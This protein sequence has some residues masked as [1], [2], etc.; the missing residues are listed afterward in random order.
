MN[1][2]MLQQL[3]ILPTYLQSPF[4]RQQ[5]RSLESLKDKQIFHAVNNGKSIVLLRAVAIHVH[6]PFQ[7]S[8]EGYA[9]WIFDRQPFKLWPSFSIVQSEYNSLAIPLPNSHYPLSNST[10]SSGQCLGQETDKG[11]DWFSCARVKCRPWLAFKGQKLDIDQVGASGQTRL[12]STTKQTPCRHCLRAATNTRG[13]S[14]YIFLEEMGNLFS[15]QCLC[16][17]PF[18]PW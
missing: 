10:V 9:P 1:H 15:F 6:I 8:H 7:C 14:V 12:F 5:S 2:A 17:K 16:T 4:M 11:A 13:S 18:L 3:V